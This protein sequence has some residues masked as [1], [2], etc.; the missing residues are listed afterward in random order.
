MNV[1]GRELIQSSGLLKKSCCR[2]VGGISISR[3]SFFGH[4]ASGLQ[5]SALAGAIGESTEG[6]WLFPKPSLNFKHAPIYK[7]ITS[8]LHYRLWHQPLI[9]RNGNVSWI[10][11]CWD[12]FSSSSSSSS[13]SFSFSSHGAE[14]VDPANKYKVGRQLVWNTAVQFLV[15]KKCSFHI[16]FAQ[17]QKFIIRN[18]LKKRKSHLYT[19]SAQCLLLES[20]GYRNYR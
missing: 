15:K 6:K 19:F 3:G 4:T 2:A 10:G 9:L 16:G 11:T 17:Y 1:L 14:P 7:Q 8:L 5:F 20:W 12:G 18:K 13:R